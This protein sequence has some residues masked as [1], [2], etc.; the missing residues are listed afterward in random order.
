MTMEDEAES[1]GSRPVADPQAQQ[2]PREQNQK[3]EVYNEVLQ[4]LQQSNCEEAHLPGFDDELWVHFNRL[5][6]RSLING[7][8]F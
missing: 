1:C 8:L 7:F 5:P 3:L 6:A 2:N 4:R